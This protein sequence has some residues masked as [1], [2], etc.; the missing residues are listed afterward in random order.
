MTIGI[1]AL[2]QRFAARPSEAPFT[3]AGIDH[4]VLLVEGM[5][6]AL[7]FYCTVLGCRPGF[8][9]PDLAMEQVWCGAAL[10]VL[11]DIS[12][13][14]GAKARP[15]IAGGRNMDHLAL[16]IGPVDPV[17]LK[18]HLG[19]HGVAIER[20][21]FH[22]GARGMGAAIYFRDPSGNMIELKSPPVY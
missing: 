3:L 4:A 19:A 13:P 12:D 18:A 17:R 16:A 22:G 10:I 20:E 5:E 1:S 8:S 11:I 14:Q 21:A 2:A 7:E 6:R 9:Y 15:K